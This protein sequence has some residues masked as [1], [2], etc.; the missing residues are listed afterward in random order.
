MI[1]I[2]D[3]GSESAFTVA[4]STWAKT[5]RAKVGTRVKKSRKLNI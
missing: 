4:L 5:E 2:S 3:L 1:R